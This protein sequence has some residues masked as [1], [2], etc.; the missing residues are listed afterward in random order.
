MKDV[1]PRSLPLRRAAGAAVALLAVTALAAA[2]ESRPAPLDEPP[3]V[4]VDPASRPAPLTRPPAAGAKA[5]ADADALREAGD[6]VMGYY[7]TPRPDRVP[8]LVRTLSKAGAV[9][10]DG[11]EVGPTAG[12]LRAIFRANGGDLAAWAG[13]WRDL[14]A[15]DRRALLT[16]LWAADTDRARAAMDALA[17][18]DADLQRY[19]A[20]L[21]S[22]RPA[23]LTGLPFDSPLVLDALWG[24][25]F[26]TGDPQYPLRV[27]D[28]LPLV[29][30]YD[31]RD[32]RRRPSG[33]A[34]RRFVLG[35]AARWSLTTNAARD[36]RLLRALKGGV[37]SAPPEVQPHLA[38]VVAA[39]EAGS[40]SAE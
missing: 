15:G 22:S 17:G 34:L 33:E 11:G 24:A 19:A 20:D 5:D 28:A 14:P 40:R 30:D 38:R 32:P 26:A 3:R 21:R 39:A 25:W 1:F 37:A 12:F 4:A 7:Q 35:D 29:G 18:D 16:S 36:E 9:G 23:P 31:P 27:A 6:F 8:E 10:R 2:Q 13:G